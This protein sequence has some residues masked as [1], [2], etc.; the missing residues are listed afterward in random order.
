MVYAKNAFGTYT[1]YNDKNYYFKNK[2]YN[3][4]ILN[5]KIF[6]YLLY[7][8]SFKIYTTRDLEDFIFKLHLFYTYLAEFFFDLLTKYEYVKYMMQ[9]SLESEYTVLDL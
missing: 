1:C 2:S 6:F 7:E 3:I 9:H 8:L 4:P 5:K